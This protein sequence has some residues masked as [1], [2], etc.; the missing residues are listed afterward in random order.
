M[1]A[2]THFKRNIVGG[3]T[4]ANPCNATAVTRCTLSQ[5]YRSVDL[6]RVNRRVCARAPN[7]WAGRVALVFKRLLHAWCTSYAFPVQGVWLLFS[8]GFCAPVAQGVQ[9]RACF[10][11]SRVA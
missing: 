5:K 9:C 4:S 2:R 7:T 8:K 6:Y 1:Y 10:D 3:G 11:G